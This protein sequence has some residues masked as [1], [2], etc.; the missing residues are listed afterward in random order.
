MTLL[1]H[2]S[3]PAVENEVDQAGLIKLCESGFEREFFG[4]LVQRGLGHR[5]RYALDAG[6]GFACGRVS[7]AGRQR[8]AELRHPATHHLS[9]FNAAGGKLILWHGW[10]DQHI[11]PLFTIQYYEAMQNTMGASTVDQFARLYLVPGVG[12]CGGGEGNPN[13]DLVTSITNWVEE[14]KVPR[15]VM[16]YQTD[17]S[18]NVTASRPVYPYPAVTAVRCDFVPNASVL[19]MTGCAKRHARSPLAGALALV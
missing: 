2:F 17:S 8:R 9:G 6:Y 10:A 13:I 1:E 5:E 12:H 4:M 3:G 14:A 16:T 19:F 15:S 7:C 18:N 11:S